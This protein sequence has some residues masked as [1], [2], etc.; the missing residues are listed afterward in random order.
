MSLS[1]AP[2]THCARHSLC[3]SSTSPYTSLWG[4][5]N[6]PEIQKDCEKA[7]GQYEGMQHMMEMFME[8]QSDSMMELD[9]AQSDELVS[10][11][12]ID[13]LIDD[14]IVAEES[15]EIEDATANRLDALKQRFEQRQKNQA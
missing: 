1:V 4:S 12:E 6:L 9:G 7:I 2:S 14:Q 8:Q 10:D 3:A 13:A 11:K 15:K 5:V